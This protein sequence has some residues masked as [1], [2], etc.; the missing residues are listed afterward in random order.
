MAHLTKK[1]RRLVEKNTGSLEAIVE[2]ARQAIK[3]CRYQFR[4]RPWNC[5][6][7]QSNVGGSI[8]GKILSLGKVLVAIHVQFSSA[9]TVCLSRALSGSSDGKEYLRKS[10]KPNL[11]IVPKD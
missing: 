8:F 4:S 9:L 3:E 7:Q 6:V 10:Q 1:Q 5:P 2:G 11:F